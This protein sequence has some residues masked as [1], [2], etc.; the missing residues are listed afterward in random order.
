MSQVEKEETS[1]GVT[2]R[3]S[4]CQVRCCSIAAVARLLCSARE[5]VKFRVKTVGSLG[6]H[7][8][9][10][11]HIHTGK[12]RPSLSPRGDIDVRLVW[13]GVVCSA[14]ATT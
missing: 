3:V 13:C 4:L 5:L 12:H 1:S 14:V 7:T 6:W 10:H 9:A 8:Y 11:T 2:T